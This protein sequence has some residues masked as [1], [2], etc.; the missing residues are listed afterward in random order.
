VLDFT[1]HTSHA[2]MTVEKLTVTYLRIDPEQL[3]EG[4][5]LVCELLVFPVGLVFTKEVIMLLQSSSRWF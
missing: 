2:P 4:A 1:V 5:W 3:P